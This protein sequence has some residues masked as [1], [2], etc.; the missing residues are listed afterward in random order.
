MNPDTTPTKSRA[1]LPPGPPS[2]SSAI[3]K[4]LLKTSL[5]SPLHPGPNMGTI[6]K[7][8]KPTR[9]GI[10]GSYDVY[11]GGGAFEAG[12]VM[13]KARFCFSTQRR[14]ECSDS[15]VKRSLANAIDETTALKFNGTLELEMKE[16]T[17]HELDKEQCVRNIDQLTHEYG[18]QSFCAIEQDGSIYD[19]LKDQHLFTFEDVIASQNFRS[20]DLSTDASKYDVFE[21]NKFKNDETGCG[22]NTYQEDE[23]Y[24]LQLL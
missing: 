11:L 13:P 18:H 2:P 3:K 5:P 14:D 16:G 24:D 21:T 6:V 12:W 20:D 8:V 15:K 19:M 22:I 23:G 9:G 1:P 4:K 10:H 7:P 17:E